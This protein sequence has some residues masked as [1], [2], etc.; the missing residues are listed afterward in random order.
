VVCFTLN[1][2][3]FSYQVVRDMVSLAYSTFKIWITIYAKTRKCYQSNT[4][5]TNK[6]SLENILAYDATFYFSNRLTAKQ[7]IPFLLKKNPTIFARLKSRI[8]KNNCAKNYYTDLIPVT[9]ASFLGIAFMWQFTLVNVSSY[10]KGSFTWIKIF[11]K[12]FFF[13]V[14]RPETG[15]ADPL[16]DPY[17]YSVTVM[18]MYFFCFLR[19][20]TGKESRIEEKEQT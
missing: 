13:L 16:L 2:V 20:C 1:I 8:W 5:N 18:M 6:Q 14:M 19:I 11:F 9:G 3:P 4:T 17:A 15:T 12:T 10:C 7:T